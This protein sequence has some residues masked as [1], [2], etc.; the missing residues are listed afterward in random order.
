M[1]RPSA[2]MANAVAL[3]AASMSPSLWSKTGKSAARTMSVTATRACHFSL[4]TFSQKAEAPLR[5]GRATGGRLMRARSR[6][7]RRRRAQEAARP[8]HQHQHQDRE[9]DDVGPAHRDVL[10]AQ[11]LDEADQDAAQH[12][13][14]DVAD[15]AQH[16]GGEGAEPCAVTDD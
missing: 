4:S 9:D 7:R 10:A 16:G 8:E 15:A 14:G 13:A 6:F 11:G 1:L 3:A 2:S 5:R 12:G